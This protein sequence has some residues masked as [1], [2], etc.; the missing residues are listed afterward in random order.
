MIERQPWNYGFTLIE[1]LV[2]IT[3]LAI[4]LALAVPSFIDMVD[5][6]RLVGATENLLSELRFAQMESVKRNKK[7]VVAFKSWNSGANWCYGL[8]EDSACDCQNTP[9]GCT[10]D[11]AQKVTSNVNYSGVKMMDLPGSGSVTFNPVRGTLAAADIELESARGKEVE[12]DISISGR[13][14]PCSPSG[15]GNIAT[16]PVCP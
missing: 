2:T 3:V 9:A 10:I 14:R 16:Y 12:I 15:S 13:I 6:N 11:G 1:L 7:I 8:K 5:K 4:F